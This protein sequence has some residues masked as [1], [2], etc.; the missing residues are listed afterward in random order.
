[1]WISLALARVGRS[2]GQGDVTERFR[3]LGHCAWGHGRAT[4]GTTC[5]STCRKLH[6]LSVD[7]RPLQRQLWR[8]RRRTRERRRTCALR[9]LRRRRGVGAVRA[10]E[11][12]KLLA[13]RGELRVGGVPRGVQARYEAVDV[14]EHC[15]HLPY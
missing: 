2:L 1:M 11:G 13:S 9:L 12:D 5:L 15:E 4:I 10:T 7:A 6:G 8:R 14:V 3:R